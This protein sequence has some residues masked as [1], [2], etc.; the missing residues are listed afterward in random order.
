MTT[1]QAIAFLSYTR[2]DD[3]FHGG[4]IT[5]FRKVLENAVHVVTGEKTFQ[6][7]QD[8]EGIVIGENWQKKLVDVIHRSSVLVPMVTPLFFNSTPCREEVTHFLDHEQSLERDDL[9]LPIYF[10]TSARLEKEEEKAKDPLAVTLGQRQ[11]FDWRE[12]ADIPLDQPAARKSM[13]ELA[14]QIAQRLDGL[15]AGARPAAA[16]APGA[17]APK[18]RRGGP[19]LGGTP[20]V[21]S[22]P[23]RR[24]L[25]R[26]DDAVA[27]NAGLAEG[28]VDH[29][30][31]EELPPRTILWVDDN[32]NYNVW[33][34]R[35]LGS[36]GIRF[37]LARDT[38][39]AERLLREKGPFAAII[40]DMGRV[41]DSRAG[42]TLLD[43]VRSVASDAPYF[44]YTT[45]T[46]A[47]ALGPIVR[48]RGV[49]GITGDP[50]A[51]VQMV[52][53]AVR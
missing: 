19:M 53:A 45:S 52:V 3:E 43:R 10:F 39:E 28:I 51:L 47:A 35:A 27:A 24:G 29:L 14:S 49:Q 46:V 2:T 34:R 23:T 20:R 31:R 1:S 25:T 26:S 40:S 9:I 5:S 6:V 21:P 32:P 41:G 30:K 16:P 13:V 37:E 12:R 7:F 33:E 18:T 36:Y 8:V 48:L 42:L 22:A 11:M 4:Y 38:D 17:V 50:D 15:D 44:I